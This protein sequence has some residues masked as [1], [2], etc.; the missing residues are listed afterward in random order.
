MEELKAEC[1]DIGGTPSDESRGRD[2]EEKYL[3]ERMKP[4]ELRTSTGTEHLQERNSLPNFNML[5]DVAPPLDL[6]VSKSLLERTSGDSSVLEVKTLSRKSEQSKMFETTTDEF[7]QEDKSKEHSNDD[8]TTPQPIVFANVE[9]QY[10]EHAN[11]N[12]SAWSFNKND[13]GGE[14]RGTEEPLEERKNAGLEMRYEK[15]SAVNAE[16]SNEQNAKFKENFVE[17]ATVESAVEISSSSAYT[18]AEYGKCFEQFTTDEDAVPCASVV[19]A[20]NTKQAF[21]IENPLM[22]TRSLSCLSCASFVVER[23]PMQQQT[24]FN[25]TTIDHDPHATFA[26]QSVSTYSIS[27][28]NTSSASNTS[29][30]R[31]PNETCNISEAESCYALSSFVNTESTFQPKRAQFAILKKRKI[32][33]P[34]QPQTNN[35]MRSSRNKVA[36][37]R[38]WLGEEPVYRIDEQGDCE[39]VGVTTVRIRDPFLIKHKTGSPTVAMHRERAIAIQR[40][41]RHKKHSRA[42]LA[43]VNARTGIV[44]S[45]EIRYRQAYS[46]QPKCMRIEELAE[47]S[48]LGVESDLVNH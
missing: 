43:P 38:R 27:E 42:G 28:P 45:T 11:S 7:F 2:S 37:L 24:E 13:E 36:P 16:V 14:V 15:T 4:L 8:I 9:S 23:K 21:V 29:A 31:Q 6:S 22:S 3:Q 39:L 46:S 12:A 1:G 48:F 17:G 34:F 41:R 10:S 47:D 44:P 32:V 25:A 33:R 20:E 5:I 40:E 19:S 30:Q 18:Q 26:N 35:V